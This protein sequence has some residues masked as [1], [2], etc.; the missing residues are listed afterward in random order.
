MNGYTACQ[1]AGDADTLIVAIALEL[2]AKMQCMIVVAS[3]SDI[4][5]SHLSLEFWKANMAKIL[6]N[7]E[8]TEQH[9]YSDEHSSGPEDNWECG[10]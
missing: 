1:S 8:S 2:A 3:D 9:V 7:R 10:S 6:M 5:S 4:R